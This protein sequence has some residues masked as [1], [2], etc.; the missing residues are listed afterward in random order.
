MFLCYNRS[1]LLF[2]YYLIMHF[3]YN[4]YIH[5]AAVD[6]PVFENCPNTQT[7]QV[8]QLIP[9]EANAFVDL[10]IEARDA[11]NQ[12]L[13]LQVTNGP[14]VIFPAKIAYNADYRVGQSFTYRAIDPQTG[15]FAECS[16]IVRLEG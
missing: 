9:G 13:D 2:C 12:L 8:F 15:L 10:Q 6:G 4:Y 5:S 14:A 7:P 3:Y 1:T 11:S 16:F